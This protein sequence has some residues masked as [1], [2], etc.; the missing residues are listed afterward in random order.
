MKCILLAGGRGDRMWPLSRKN[1][2]KQFIT[3]KNNHSIFQE[4]IARNMS[5]CDEF[6]IVTNK[7]YQS[8]IESQMKAFRG[9]TY[10]CIYEEEGR[11]TAG[12]VLL[13]ALQLPDS[14]LIFVV[15]SDQLISGEGYKN[16]VIE[17]RNLAK[18]DNLVTIGDCGLYIFKNGV[19]LNE[20]S[21]NMPGLKDTC[22]KAYSRKKTIGNYTYFPADVLKS[23]PH[24]SI[25][26]IMLKNTE[27]SRTVEQSFECQ[28]MGGLD[29]LEKVV[30]RDAIG[31]R[32]SKRGN[33]KVEPVISNKCENTT[34]INRCD[35]KLVVVNHLKDVLVVNTGDAVYIGQKGQSNDL[36]E[37]IL[38][39]KELWDYFNK[40]ELY[41]R[42]WGTYEILE[43][44]TSIAYQVRKV[45]IFPGKTIYY[46]KHSRKC[47]HICIVSGR[48]KAMVGNE[49]IILEPGDTLSINAG[50][51]HQLSCISDNMLVFIETATNVVF[52]KEDII[53][54]D[55]SDLSEGSLGYTYDKFVKLSPAYK[56]YLWGGNKLK[57]EFGKKTDLTT[58][59]E[60]WELSAHPDGQS[61]VASGKY[62]GLLFGDYIRRIGED[63]LGWKF[64][65]MRNFP[66][67]IKLID[68]KKDLSIQVHPDD[69]YALE[70]ENE[71]GKSEL[72][73][74]I[75]CEEDS[76]I[77]CGFNRNVTK[78]EVKEASEN[79]TIVDLLNKVYVKPGETYYIEAGTVHAIGKGCLICEIQQNSNSTYR[80]YDFDRIDKY[81]NKRKLDLEKALDVLDVSSYAGNKDC[82]YFAVKVRKCQGR[83]KL[84]MSTET[85]AAIIILE[86]EGSISHG[87]E[88]LEFTKGNCVFVPA[89]DA[90]MDLNGDFEYIEARI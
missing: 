50:T 37:I 75:S 74:I 29:D 35:D 66:L 49:S 12:A 55:S 48:C 13:S 60:S 5:F 6:I 41:Y 64:Q 80:L 71:Y 16:N 59:A 25:G 10:R 2:P 33:T 14:E 68:A 3:I 82:K 8:V 77:Y 90:V 38:E 70:H 32:N 83:S 21:I 26:D 54:V 4:T 9:L 88:K 61:L 45:K 28:D 56:D 65:G 69:D 73:Y 67:M 15:A 40:S 78:K 51:E 87:D 53:S 47:E 81:G 23:I 86:G 42:K 58:L 27:R 62:E 34:V 19:F 22:E 20:I 72:W 7:D 79:G 52:K 76:Y 43:E 1:Y 84:N 63:A 17:A 44:N 89:T 57:K 24:L 30:L 85:F 18:K 39:R 11:G 46:H 31:K 36:K